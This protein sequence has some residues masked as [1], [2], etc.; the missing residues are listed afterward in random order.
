MENLD[1]DIFEESIHFG[2]NS[3]TKKLLKRVVFWAK[4]ISIL[5]LLAVVL[6][7]LLFGL[8]VI[9]RE[10]ILGDAVVMWIMLA[11]F[12]IPLV[13]LFVFALKAESALRESDSF[14]LQKAVEYLKSYF[15]SIGISMI[16]VF[17][18]FIIVIASVIITDY[19]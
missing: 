17:I 19:N 14:I 18:L 4:F 10:M 9:E 5:G 11:F 15:K 16:L 3:Q 7:S 6:L 1:K 13:Y 2:L 12:I 8:S